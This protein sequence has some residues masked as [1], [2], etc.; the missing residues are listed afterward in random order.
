VS[1]KRVY[2]YMVLGNICCGDSRGINNTH[3]RD[4]NAFIALWAKDW[5]FFSWTSVKRDIL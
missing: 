2:G 5:L 4:R 3:S 1:V